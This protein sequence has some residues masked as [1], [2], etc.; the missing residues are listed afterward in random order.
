[1]ILRALEDKTFLPIG[2]DREASSNF[3]LIAGTNRDL[4]SAIGNGRFREDLLRPSQPL[5]LRA[6]EPQ[7]AARRYRAEYRFELQRFTEREGAAALSVVRDRAGG[8]VVIQL[9][10]SRRLGH[11][12]GDACPWRPDLS[13][14]G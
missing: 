4:G 2:T 10:R 5:E 13:C 6:T 1:M 8:R 9:P 3:Q 11:P 14:G 12:H 7:G